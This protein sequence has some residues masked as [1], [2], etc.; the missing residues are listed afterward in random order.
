MIVVGS[1][2]FIPGSYYVLDPPP[3]RT[4]ISIPVFNSLNLHT[5]QVF[6]TFQAWRE[7]PGY[8]YSGAESLPIHGIDAYFV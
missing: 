4:I 1:L 6:L 2:M 3:H 7:E 5:S 8:R